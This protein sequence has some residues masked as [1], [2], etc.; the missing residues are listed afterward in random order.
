MAP[1]PPPWLSERPGA[2]HVATASAHGLP[3]AH[4]GGGCTPGDQALH[5]AGAGPG[6]VSR[7]RLLA[8]LDQGLAGRLILLSG[9]AGSGKTTLLSEWLARGERPAAWLSLEPG[10]GDPAR[11]LGYLIAALR[12]V[13]PGCGELS[14]ALLNAVP[15]PPLESLLTTLINEIAAA[16]PAGR[17]TILVLDDYHTIASTAIHDGVTFLLEHLPPAMHL[18]IA[19]RIDPPLPLSRFRA[20][21][22]MVEIR[23]SDLRFT[24]DETAAFLNQEMKLGLAADAIAALEARA[25]GWIAGLQMV[26]LSMQGRS[27]QGLSVKLLIAIAALRLLGATRKPLAG[28]ALGAAAGAGYGGFEAF[29]VFNQVF[30]SGLTWATVQL[31]GM[32]ALLDFFE[33]LFAVPF[34]VSSTAVAGYGYASGRPWRFLLLAILLHSAINYSIILG[35][36]GVLS[37]VG[38]D[39]WAAV[40]SAATI[41]LAFWL[42]H[43]AA[44]SAA[45]AS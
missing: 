4:R 15:L 38:L 24:L 26:A 11:L 8:R 20:R 41:G 23:A 14:G 42:R 2:R 18:V 17:P 32:G 34:H 5:P 33:R 37:V 12:T 31:A 43:R 3:A 7:P 1:G 45:K 10:D 35:Q 13:L 40:L 21:G 29:W 9:P 44:R 19:T 28:L 30:A 27:P 16:A 6:L 25:E 22:Q 39:T 36:A